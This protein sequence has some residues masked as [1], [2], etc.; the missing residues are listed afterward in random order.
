[1]A[2]IRTFTAYVRINCESSEIAMLAWPE[3]GGGLRWEARRSCPGAGF[4]EP[5]MCAPFCAV[6]KG[7]DTI[8][9]SIYNRH[10]WAFG[11]CRWAFPPQ[12]P[13]ATNMSMLLRGVLNK[14]MG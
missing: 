3:A 1:M 13:Y 9:Q 12:L 2:G 8:M 4:I 6:F 5:S 14:H 11:E 10:Q 7:D